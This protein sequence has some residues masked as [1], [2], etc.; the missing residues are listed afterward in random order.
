LD[1]P[2]QNPPSQQN[3]SNQQNVQP[4]HPNANIGTDE[5]FSEQV[6]EHPQEQIEPQMVQVAPSN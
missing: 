5:S 2:Q 1:N 4:V 3:L 6:E